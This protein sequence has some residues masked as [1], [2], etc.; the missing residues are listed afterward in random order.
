LRRRHPDLLIDTCASGG[1]RN[2]LETLRRSVPLLRSD[3]PLTGFDATCSEGQQC[4][5]FGI[6]LW[7]P[8]HGTGM[9]LSDAYTMRSGFVPAYRL[10][11]DVRDRKVDLALLKRAVA[12][13]RQA[14]KYFLGD[15]YPLT[16]WS[17]AKDV[18]IAWQYDHPEQGEG[19]VQAFRRAESPYELA[20]F[21]LR[22]LDADARYTVRNL[23]QQETL[24]SFSG[25]ELMERGLAITL[26]SQRSSGVLIYR[27]L[28]RGR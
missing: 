9:P 15:F 4:Q 10:G 22:G 26:T 14:E 19:L 2:D 28:Q 17:L 23:D 11:W 5:T 18:W 25:S 20:R 8:F 1:R 3:Y 24:P 21:R 16:L 6:S 7:M 27:R 12:E 13:F